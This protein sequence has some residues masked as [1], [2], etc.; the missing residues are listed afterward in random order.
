MR[1]TQRFAKFSPV[2]STQRVK[3]LIAMV[4]FFFYCCIHTFTIL[5]FSCT[6]I[7]VIIIVLAERDLEDSGAESDQSDQYEE[8][9]NNESSDV[10][11]SSQPSMRMIGI[12]I[13][14]FMTNFSCPTRMFYF[15]F[16]CWYV[17]FLARMVIDESEDMQSLR[18]INRAIRGPISLVA[19][20]K[21][22]RDR[23]FS[24]LAV[25]Y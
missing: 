7:T 16:C 6:D 20:Q 19:S 17:L 2:M 3:K 1:G 11:S 13:I 8:D 14:T 9:G 12:Q 24:F 23:H 18:T 21:Q 22:M 4:S 25:R 5:L 15:I 10:P